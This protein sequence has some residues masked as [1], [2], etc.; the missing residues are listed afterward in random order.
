MIRFA[1][2]V[3]GAFSLT[4]PASATGGCGVGCYSTSEGACVRDGWQQGLPVRNVCPATS[5]PSPPLR[6][7]SPMESA[8]HDVHSALNRPRY[9][10]SWAKRLSE[11]E[12][13][14]QRERA[15]HATK[16][17]GTGSS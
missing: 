16:P 4:E 12:N 15:G 6:P 5:Q 8:I 14:R 1:C 2:L 17:L 11:N 7:I 13:A 9:L 3:L 10:T